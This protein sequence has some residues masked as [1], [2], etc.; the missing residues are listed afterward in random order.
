MEERTHHLHPTFDAVSVLRLPHTCASKSSVYSRRLDVVRHFVILVVA[1]S[2]GLS[3]GRACIFP[4]CYDGAY[5]EPFFGAAAPY[6]R[7]SKE[8]KSCRIQGESVHPYICTYDALK[9]KRDKVT[10]VYIGGVFLSL[11]VLN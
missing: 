3:I 8:T 2:I 11:K 7:K 9:D 4:I 5:S 1:R 10:H 6:G